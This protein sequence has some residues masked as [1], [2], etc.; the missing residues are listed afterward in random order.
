MGCVLL[1]T[2]NIIKKNQSDG[3]SRPDKLQ[4]QLLGFWG[5]R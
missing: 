1:N 5:H 2:Q 4:A 3:E